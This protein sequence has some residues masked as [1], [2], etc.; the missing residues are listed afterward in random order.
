MGGNFT[1]K[2]T[3]QIYTYGDLQE[4]MSHVAVTMTKR[5]IFVFLVLSLPP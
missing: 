1:T 4:S 2:T 3:N 5:Y